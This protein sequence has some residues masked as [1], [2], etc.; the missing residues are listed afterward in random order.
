MEDAQSLATG[1]LV[2]QFEL[3]GLIV[4]LKGVRIVLH[5][6]NASEFNTVAFEL[7]R[8]AHLPAWVAAGDIRPATTDPTN[9]S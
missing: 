7:N 5:F 3:D 6:V 1:T 2:L 4:E 9:R 8:D